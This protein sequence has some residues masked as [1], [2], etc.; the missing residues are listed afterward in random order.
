MTRFLFQLIHLYNYTN[1]STIF[2]VRKVVKNTNKE[3]GNIVEGEMGPR[4]EDL[5]KTE[6]CNLSHPDWLYMGCFPFS[7][8]TPHPSLSWSGKLDK[9]WYLPSQSCII[10]CVK[11][12]CLSHIIFRN[13]MQ[14][15]F[16]G[17]YN[18]Y[19]NQ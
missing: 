5:T 17:L 1:Y 4:G 8:Y 16:P 15:S 12:L 18:H 11:R 9:D 2:E 3:N 6:L 7:L 10:I 13:W 14:K 19:M